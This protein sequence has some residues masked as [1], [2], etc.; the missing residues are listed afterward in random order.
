MFL[1]NRIIDYE[2]NESDILH[3]VQLKGEYRYHSIIDFLCQEGIECSWKNIANYIKYDKRLLINSF[4]Y[5][6]F[7]EELFKSFVIEHLEIKQSKVINYS[8]ST[9]LDKYLSIGEKANYDG[10]DLLT[11]E[12]EKE[13]IILFRNR[14][15]HNKI[16]LDRSYNKHSLEEVLQIFVKALPQSYRE[17]FIKDINNCSKRLV[18]NLWH[19][20]F[21]ENRQ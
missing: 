10:I 16:L 9:V 7:L 6:V 14:V 20:N 18:D 4:K 15:V 21:L 1:E 5:I 8:F 2:D 13:T 3:W 19:I 17:G 11:L 12:N